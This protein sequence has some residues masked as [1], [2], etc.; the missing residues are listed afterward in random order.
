[1]AKTI[2]DIKRR[3]ILADVRE[4]R[5]LDRQ[6]HFAASGTLEAWL[7]RHDVHVDRRKEASRQA[8]RGRQSED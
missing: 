6:A 7:G 5:G 1:M 4:I 2:A 3:R 8:C